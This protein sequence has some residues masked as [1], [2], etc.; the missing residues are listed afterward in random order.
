MIPNGLHISRDGNWLKFRG[1]VACHRNMKD[2]TFVTMG[3]G[4][5][6]YYDLILDNSVDMHGV[7][8]IQGSGEIN[9]DGY[10]ETVTVYNFRLEKV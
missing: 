9:S 10:N 8:I 5:G 7:D 2:I 6:V 3:D 4:S 1:L